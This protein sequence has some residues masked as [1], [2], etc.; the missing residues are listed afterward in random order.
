MQAQILRLAWPTLVAQLAIML[1]SVIDTVMTGRLSAI[2]QAA[3]GLGSSIYISIHLAFTGVLLALSPVAAQHFGAGRFADIGIEFRQTVLLALLMCVPATLLLM[4]A[5]LWTSL[6]NPPTEVAA[7]TSRYLDAIALAMPAN[8]LFRVYSALNNAISRP[9]MIMLINL[10]ALLVK[11]PLN[12]L[13]IYG[14]RL[15]IA[16]VHWQLPAHG[17]AGCGI[18]TCIIYWG[19]M[20]LG[21]FILLTNR[22]YRQFAL[23][24]SFRPD[25]QRIRNIAKI[26]IP[27][28][29]SY[30]VEITAF[31]FI[32]LFL[33]RTGAVITASHQIVSNLVGVMYMIPLALAT[34][35]S[36]ITAQSIGANSRLQTVQTIRLGFRIILVSALATC[37]FVLMLR[38]PLAQ[39]YSQDPAVIT[40]SINL[41]L[42]IVVYH[43]FDAIQ[44]ALGFTLRAF[45]ITTEPMLIYVLALWG[46]G[47]GLGYSLAFVFPQHWLAPAQSFWCAGI[48]ANL[49]AALGLWAIG[50]K[51]VRAVIRQLSN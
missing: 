42:W 4:A 36:T 15:D 37:L 35:I 40:L 49:C 50:A 9:R 10:L 16:G 34:A 41:M 5:P 45:K 1:N 27:I 30:M 51:K 38:A 26:G 19:M 43:F 48:L 13:L 2:D 7:I 28:G 23:W 24:E 44:T 21:L 39:L 3:I 11:I 33:A 31:T 12:A 29:L 22:D 47:L 17:G 14:L 6:A 46:I 8:L 25:W 32:T 20:L 18:A